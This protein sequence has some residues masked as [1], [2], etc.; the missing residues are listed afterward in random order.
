MPVVSITRLRVRAWR[1]LPSFFVA[2]LRSARQAARSEGNLETK[3][4]RDANRV[5][6]T[7]TVWRDEPSMK[8]FMQAA[9]HGAAMRRLLE[10]CDEAALV[11][12]TQDDAAVPPWPEAHARMQRDGR[13]SKVHHPSA[14]HDAFVI[15]AP[16]GRATV[17]LRAA[18]T[19]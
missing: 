1:F 17:T 7:A 12:W 16:A 15:A 10:W 13:R 18:S 6:W 8:A 3:L 2:A 14:A 9:P 11:R 4:L 5:F 19:S